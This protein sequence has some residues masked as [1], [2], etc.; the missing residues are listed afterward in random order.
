MSIRFV[1]NADGAGWLS[2][3]PDGV[4]PEVAAG[5]PS[6]QLP[7]PQLLKVELI[8]VENGREY[9][10]ILEGPNG[11]KLASVKVKGVGQSY[12][13]ANGQ[14]LP[15]GTVKL[16]RRKQQFWFGGKGPFSAFTERTN[17]VPL[18]IWDL[19]IPDAPHES[20]AFYK[21]NSIYYKTWFHIGHDPATDRYLHLGLISHGCATVRPF[22]PND[23]EPRLAGRRDAEIGI[24]VPNSKE[25]TINWTD[26]YQYLINRRKGDSKSVGTITV[27]DL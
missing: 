23:N 14:H 16:N 5:N 20:P 6:L 21:S 17:P 7:L 22:I 2:V 1:T 8:K 25:A 12:L 13:S 26:L 24:P 3:V 10:K 27:V 15:G 4:R 9:F 11:G 19:E 18:G